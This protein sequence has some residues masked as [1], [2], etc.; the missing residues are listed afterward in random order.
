MELKVC[1][2][3][4]PDITYLAFRDYS[5]VCL[6]CVCVCVFPC[7]CVSVCVSASVCV[8]I[9]RVMNLHDLCLI[10]IDLS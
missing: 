7:I 2:I 8:S 3:N 6:W 4:I 1:N 9:P 10:L 5:P